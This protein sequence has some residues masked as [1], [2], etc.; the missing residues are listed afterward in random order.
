MQIEDQ[1]LLFHDLKYRIV[2]LVRLNSTLGIS[3]DASRVRLDAYRAASCRKGTNG[4][5]VCTN[6]RLQ[7]FLPS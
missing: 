5:S 3:R 7:P 2:D 4:S 1:V 6:Q